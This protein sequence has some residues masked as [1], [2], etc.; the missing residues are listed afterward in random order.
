MGLSLLK[1]CRLQRFGVTRSELDRYKDVLLRDSAQM[2]TQSGSVPSVDNL[3]F[4][5]ESL[6]LGH[7]VMDHR[8]GHDVLMQVANSI[9]LEEVNA[10]AR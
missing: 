5:M 6:T 2:A 1:V 3:D 4:L 7:V 9:T 10:I 8:Q